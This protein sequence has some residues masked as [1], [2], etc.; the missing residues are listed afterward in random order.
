MLIA[1]LQEGDWKYLAIV[2]LV[3]I[4][5]VLLCRLIP[6]DDEDNTDND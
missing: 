2:V 1:S 4:A 6:W 3:S 5:F